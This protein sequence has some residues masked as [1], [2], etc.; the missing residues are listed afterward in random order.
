[1]Q[2]LSKSGRRLVQNEEKGTQPL[3][4]HAGHG[5]THGRWDNGWPLVCASSSLQ[6]KTPGVQIED[7]L[8]CMMKGSCSDHTGN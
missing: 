4:L 1:M 2:T 6:R 7:I 8:T 3:W 5:D